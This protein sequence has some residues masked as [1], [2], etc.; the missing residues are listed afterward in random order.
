VKAIR[1]YRYGP[2]DVLA[3][4]DVG[5]PAVGAR[6]VLVRVRA[7]SVNPLDWHFMK[8]TPYVVRAAAGLSLLQVTDER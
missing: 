6:D 1:Y 4:L 3:L 5:V 7:A 8:G 2:P